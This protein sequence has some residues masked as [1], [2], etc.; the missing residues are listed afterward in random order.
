MKAI[1]TLNAAKRRNKEIN[2]YCDAT[3]D[4]VKQKRNTPCPTNFTWKEKIR[5]LST[6]QGPIIETGNNIGH[7]VLTPTSANNALHQ[8]NHTITYNPI[9]LS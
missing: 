8:N 4:I 6:N 3:Y 9:T 5:Y 1:V 2:R 7:L